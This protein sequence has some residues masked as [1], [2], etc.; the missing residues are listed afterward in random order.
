MAQGYCPQGAHNLKGKTMHTHHSLQGGQIRYDEDQHCGL[1]FP[2]RGIAL[3]RRLRSGHQKMSWISKMNEGEL[4]SHR[5]QHMLLDS[6]RE[7]DSLGERAVGRFGQRVG[8]NRDCGHQLS[9]TGS[10]F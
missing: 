9:S 4:S 1:R 7:S 2:Q 5:G 3:W 6:R 8:C 10:T